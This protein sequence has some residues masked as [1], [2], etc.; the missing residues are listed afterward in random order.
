MSMLYF[1]FPLNTPIKERQKEIVTAKSDIS[2]APKTA[3]RYHCLRK[4]KNDNISLETIY[5]RN[6]LIKKKIALK[7]L[8]DDVIFSP[9]NLNSLP[10]LQFHQLFCRHKRNEF[11]SQ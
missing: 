4:K 2:G 9:R 10:P 11:R 5:P 8:Y 1:F 3:M 6:M 7:I